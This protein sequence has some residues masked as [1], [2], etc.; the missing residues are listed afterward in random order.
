MRATTAQEAHVNAVNAVRQTLQTGER[1]PWIDEIDSP[2]GYARWRAFEDLLDRQSELLKEMD[3]L[4]RRFVD[5]RPYIKGKTGYFDPMGIVGSSGSRID[6]LC[7]LF[8]AK[9]QLAVHAHI[10]YGKEQ[11]EG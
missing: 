10:D 11:D 4:Q 8:D 5:A 6:V 1:A 7:A 9:V 2:A 3:Q